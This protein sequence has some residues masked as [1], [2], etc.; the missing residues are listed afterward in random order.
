LADGRKLREIRDG[1]IGKGTTSV[2]PL[3]GAQERNRALAPEG[4]GE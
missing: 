1:T 2:V 4:G 3:E